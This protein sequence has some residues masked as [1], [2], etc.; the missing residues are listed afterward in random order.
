MYVMFPCRTRSIEIQ[1]TFAN[2]RT[3]TFPQALA[4]AIAQ[5]GQVLLLLSKELCNYSDSHHCLFIIA[6][7]RKCMNSCVSQRV[8]LQW[9]HDR[10][11][12]TSQHSNCV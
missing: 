3:R 5:L 7:D 6:I 10:V 2:T 11:N 9:K 4:P 1:I 12:G 8:C